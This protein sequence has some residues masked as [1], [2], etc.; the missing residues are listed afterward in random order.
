MSI[1]LNEL[2][3]AGFVQ[4]VAGEGYELTRLGTELL[5]AFLPINAFAERWAKSRV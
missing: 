2:R 3:A 4:N 5:D 1:R